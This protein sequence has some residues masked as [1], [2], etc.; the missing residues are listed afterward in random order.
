M[1]WQA[2]HRHAGECGQGQAHADTSNQLAGQE[3]C[4]EVRFRA[5]LSDIPQ[6][7]RPEEE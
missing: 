1:R 5:E 2:G 6:D 7:A 4:H 3:L